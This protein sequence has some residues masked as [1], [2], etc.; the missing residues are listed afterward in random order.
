MFTTNVV[1]IAR[2]TN[3]DDADDAHNYLE[4]FGRSVARLRATMT[5]FPVRSF[6]VILLLTTALVDSDCNLNGENGK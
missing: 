1:V 5:Y 6:L 3:D 2:M 4:Q